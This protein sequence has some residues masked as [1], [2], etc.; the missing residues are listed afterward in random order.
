[1]RIV[2][3]ILSEWRTGKLLAITS[4]TAGHLSPPEDCIGTAANHIA[5][6]NFSCEPLTVAAN[7]SVLVNI[8]SDG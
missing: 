7:R 2:E 1:M 3:G 8:K 4:S 6:K 5:A